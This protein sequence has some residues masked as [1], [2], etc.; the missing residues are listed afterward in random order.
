VFLPWPAIDGVD[1]TGKGP[2]LRIMSRQGEALFPR[3]PHWRVRT[4]RRRFGS[5]F[6]VDGKRSVEHPEQLAH[7]LDQ[8][9]R[10]AGR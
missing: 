9:G 7:R 8:L 5:A 1:A 2:A 6:V 3:R 4:T 10:W